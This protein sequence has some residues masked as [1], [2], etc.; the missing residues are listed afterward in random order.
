MRLAQWCGG[1]AYVVRSRPQAGRGMTPAFF[2]S[3]LAR[4]RLPIAARERA[5]PCWGERHATLR[6]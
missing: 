5:E 2:Y 4:R 6:P 1:V 3:K